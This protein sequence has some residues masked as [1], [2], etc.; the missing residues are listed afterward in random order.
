M[1]DR[2]I[3]VCYNGNR[4]SLTTINLEGGIMK[5]AAITTDKKGIMTITVD[6]NK[7]FG[8]SRSGKTTIIATSSGNVEVEEGIYLG[9]NV[10]RYANPK[11]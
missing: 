7:E 2:V 11:A 6:T 9:L 8:L 4:Q 5:N 10:Y 1:L 3:G